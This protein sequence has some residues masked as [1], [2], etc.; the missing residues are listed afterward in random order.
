[1]MVMN[2]TQWLQFCTEAKIVDPTQ[3]GCSTADLEVS[4]A[5]QACQRS[6]SLAL[7]HNQSRIT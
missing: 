5:A 4:R 6:V 3:R 2:M 1:M 7:L